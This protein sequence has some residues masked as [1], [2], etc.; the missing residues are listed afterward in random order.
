MFKD[1]KHY[2]LINGCRKTGHTLVGCILDAHPNMMFCNQHVRTHELKGIG[3]D[4]FFKSIYDKSVEIGG[5]AKN[6]RYYVDGYYQGTYK[7]KLSVIGA[8]DIDHIGRNTGNDPDFI[9]DIIEKI[10][11][12]IKVL[13]ILRNPFDV[14]ATKFKD[15]RNSLDVYTE[16]DRIF[17]RMLGVQRTIDAFPE[18]DIYI[19]YQEYLIEKPK[20]CIKEM[21]KHLEVDWDKG[22]LKACQNIIYENP[23]KTRYERNKRF[24]VDGSIEYVQKEIDKYEFLSGY[25][26]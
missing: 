14:I 6:G 3:Q 10:V 22:Y 20:E 11:I 13:I 1:L 26:Y 2:C 15:K 17:R 12:P 23:H 16:T 7:D 4:N 18:E 8:T 9:Y 5:M 19:L 21:L 25:T 24:W